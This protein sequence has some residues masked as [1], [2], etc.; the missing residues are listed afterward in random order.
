MCIRDSFWIVSIYQAFQ[1]L[2]NIAVVVKMWEGLVVVMKAWRVG[3]IATSAAMMANPVGVVIGAVAAVALLLAKN[4][5]DMKEAGYSTGEAFLELGKKILIFTGPIGAAV[6]FLA[7]FIQRLFQGQ[8]AMEALK[9]SALE[10]ANNV[11]FGLAGKIFG[12]GT[13]IER[14]AAADQLGTTKGAPAPKKIKDG[15]I[16]KDGQVTTFADNDTLLAG[17]P[18]GGL[19]GA[20]GQLMGGSMTGMLAGSSG[21]GKGA[22]PI[23]GFLSTLANAKQDRERAEIMQ[24]YGPLLK[25]VI[26]DPIMRAL[27]GGTGDGAGGINVK[28][29]IGQEEVDATVVKALNSPH[30]RSAMLPWSPGASR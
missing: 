13:N 9:N 25:E 23:L 27:G 19:A 3:W 29:Y 28:V 16:L 18:G 11:S 6:S 12:F 15:A 26:T 10:F 22:N 5:Y 14:K 4:F 30:G 8:S 21:M 17:R 7:S 2:K 1:K 24:M 20:L